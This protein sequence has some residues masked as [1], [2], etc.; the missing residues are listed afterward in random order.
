MATH[1]Q[2]LLSD[3]AVS[4]DAGRYKVKA[5]SGEKA[6]P[7][8]GNQA[9]EDNKKES[10]NTTSRQGSHPKAEESCQQRSCKIKD[11]YQ[12]LLRY[13]SSRIDDDGTESHLTEKGGG[14]AA[15]TL[16]T[17]LGEND[18]EVDETQAAGDLE[19]PNTKIHR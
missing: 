10:G 19:Q 13:Q 3:M 5:F 9:S 7:Y 8:P 11:C 1:A 12:A 16:K 17:T 15:A 2:A 14:H 18:Q 4:H 6:P